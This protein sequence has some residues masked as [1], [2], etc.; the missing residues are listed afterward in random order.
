M[1]GSDPAQGRYRQ[2]YEYLAARRP[3]LVLGEET[4]A[5]RIVAETDSGFA[6]SVWDPRSISGGL[7]RIVRDPPLPLQAETAR[8]YAYP[9][10]IERLAEVIE[11]VAARRPA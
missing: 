1:T 5:A 10:L 7:R 3:I 4:E 2:A 11:G 6:V 8:Q 9:R